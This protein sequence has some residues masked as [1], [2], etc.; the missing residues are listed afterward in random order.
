M[1]GVLFTL[2][3]LFT[4]AGSALGWSLGKTRIRASSR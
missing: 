1:Q 3:P 2:I 4:V